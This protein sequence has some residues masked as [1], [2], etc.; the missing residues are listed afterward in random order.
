MNCRRLFL[1][2]GFI[3]LLALDNSHGQDEEDL[4]NSV[5]NNP[6][7]EENSDETIGKLLFD[8][9]RLILFWVIFIF[10]TEFSKH[11]FRIKEKTIKTGQKAGQKRFLVTLCIPPYTFRRKNEASEIGNNAIFCCTGCE[12]GYKQISA[13]GILMNLDANGHPEY[14]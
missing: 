14:R 3:V 7:D 4:D 11:E 9:R 1:V 6:D 12:K 2:I 10:I 8:T 13:H 5:N